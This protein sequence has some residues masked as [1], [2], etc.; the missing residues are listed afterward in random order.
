MPKPLMPKPLM[1]KTRTF[2]LYD[3]KVEI[4]S[5]K[6]GLE[7]ICNHHVGDYFELSGENLSIPAGKTFSMYAL[8]SVLP[9]LPAKQRVTDEND[10]MT[11]D[12]RVMCPDP[13][14]EA[15][16]KVMRTGVREFKTED[17]TL[18]PKKLS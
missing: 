7:D 10:W 1:P 11:M 9:L 15:V 8:A 5:V 16:M 2:K 12:D 13:N 14:C 17:V 4:V 18:I 3:L 6:K